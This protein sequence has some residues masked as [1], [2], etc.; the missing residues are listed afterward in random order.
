MKNTL[1]HTGNTI[2]TVTGLYVDVINPHP[3]MFCIEDIAHSLSHQCRFGGH[4]HRFYSVAQHSYRV[5]KSRHVPQRHQ[6]T[7][8]MHDATEAYLL[9]MPRPIKR[10]LPDYKAVEARLN[11]AIAEK[12]GFDGVFDPCIK[13]ADNEALEY[14]F[15][16]LVKNPQS[17]DINPMLPE[18]AKKF[19]LDRYY[20]L[21]GF[22]APTQKERI[23]F[24]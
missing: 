15:E 14:E 12:F 9:D 11:Y 13:A 21:T 6:L 16:H 4:L 19:F 18:V 3:D 7:A 10:Q 17:Q 24:K 8:L 1:L 23:S 22:Q 20:E 5:S 2:R